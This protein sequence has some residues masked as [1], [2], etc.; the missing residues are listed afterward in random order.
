M[1]IRFAVP[2]QSIALLVALLLGGIEPSLAQRTFA[3]QDIRESG[4]TGEAGAVGHDRDIRLNRVATVRE[5]A[6]VSSPTIVISAVPLT[7]TT[8]REP[9]LRPV[10]DDIRNSRWHKTMVGAGIGAAVAT[11]TWVVLACVAHCSGNSDFSGAEIYLT[12]VVA[13]IGAGVGGL[14]AFTLA[15]PRRDSDSARERN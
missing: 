8:Y 4:F 3:H 15:T 5:S 13:G 10:L 7:L 12:P 6:L 14:I 2:L 1:K 9:L 11:V